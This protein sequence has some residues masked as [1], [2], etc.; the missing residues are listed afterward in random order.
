MS[1]TNI[2]IVNKGKGRDYLSVSKLKTDP[3]YQNLITRVK[4]NIINSK[5]KGETVALNQIELSDVDTF[6]K[7]FG[8]GKFNIETT[9]F[10]PGIVFHRS[11]SVV[12]L[13]TITCENK[14]YCLLTVQPRMPTGYRYF[15]ELIA[16]MTDGNG[17]FSLVMKDEILEETGLNINLDRLIYLG[18]ADAFLNNNLDEIICK[19][20][21]STSG[22]YK[23]L[24]Q[25]DSE[26][27]HRGW[28]N[29]AGGC[30]E[31]SGFYLYETEMNYNEFNTFLGKIEKE[32]YG[33][34]D[35]NIK[36]IV[37]PLDKVLEVSPSITSGHALALYNRHKNQKFNTPTYYL[38]KMI[39]YG[40][41]IWIITIMILIVLIKI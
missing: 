18:E 41:Y 39:W 16:G 40:V 1:N 26:K 27:S 22:T 9:P 15:I 28:F 7:K 12:C 20:D 10:I 25:G 2:N 3:N 13:F 24:T 19:S 21:K 36:L 4:N 38:K 23:W 32:Q 17:K 33:I 29:S 14:Q 37:V 6:G 34:E 35:E 31:T 5:I 8:F 11:P 30:S